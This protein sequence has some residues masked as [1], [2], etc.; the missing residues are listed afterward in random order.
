MKMSKAVAEKAVA[1][2]DIYC[3]KAITVKGNDRE[4]KPPRRETTAQCSC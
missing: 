2:K 3:K 1:A 4:R